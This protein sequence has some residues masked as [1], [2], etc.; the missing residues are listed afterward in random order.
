MTEQGTKFSDTGFNIAVVG[1]TGAVGQ[2]ML[3]ILAERDFPVARLRAMASARSAG[4]TVEFGGQSVVVE[5]LQDASFEGVD[6]ALFSAGSAP[7]LEHAPRAVQQGCIVI[8]N[9]SAFRMNADTPLV[10]PEV[11]PDAIVDQPGIIANPNCS[12]IQMVVA[13]KPLADTAGLKRVVVST[14]QSA[15]GAGQKGIDELLQSTRDYLDGDTDAADTASTD[16]VFAYPLAF[17]VLPHIDSFLD[18]GF[19][20]EEM[21]MVNET[22]KIL[23]HDTLD[24]AATCVRVP[25]VRSH[26]ES[27]T[28]D[29]N[30]PLS[31]EQARKLWAD[32]PGVR[33][34]DNPAQLVYPR[35]RQAEH[36]D[37]TW[38][39]RVRQDLDRP[40]TLHFWVV[41]D[42]LRKGAAL[43]A[44]QIAEEIVA[45]RR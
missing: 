7:S 35:A 36:T 9:T 44:V 19:T 24:V 41:S 43:N 29:L 31:A 8:D 18:S 2:E 16:N 4:G 22:R 25:A 39:G 21:K 11:N 32:A 23:G 5:D 40:S 13:L 3:A 30:K 26:S 45:Q 34:L 20:R 10:V 33:L 37:P 27:V 6:F 12:T 15:S 42:N 1:A 28:V 17:D 38:V 14:Y